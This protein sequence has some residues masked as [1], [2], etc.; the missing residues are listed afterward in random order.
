MRIAREG[1]EGPGCVY[2]AR[3]NGALGVGVSLADLV[4]RLLEFDP[5]G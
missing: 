5:E 3:G 4:P 2:E 1:A